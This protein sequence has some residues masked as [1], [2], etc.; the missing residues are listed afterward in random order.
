[1]KVFVVSLHRCA[2]QSVAVFLTQAG[3]SS[4][5]FP[6]IVDGVDY[7]SQVTGRETDLHSITGLLRPVFDSFE[8]LSDLPL[9]VLYRQIDAAYPNSR[10]IAIR[11]DPHDWLRSVRRHCGSR[12]L[13]PYERVQY[14]RYL[15]ER[16]T[17]LDEVADD[18]LLEMYDQHYR[19]VREYFG[20]RDDLLLLDLEDVRIGSRL[21]TFLGTRVIEFPR[22]DYKNPMT[23]RAAWLYAKELGQR[24]DMFAAR[25]TLR[26]AVRTYPEMRRQAKVWALWAATYTNYRWFAIART[27]SQRLPFRRR[28]TGA[29]SGHG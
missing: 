3:F 20:E 14:W 24:G 29:A 28:A 16:P 25:A 19:A 12:P 4:C 8:A 2:T 18:R 10:F 6:S 1:M 26:T 7:E 9:P 15:P 5:H 17:S 21:S 11:R 22:V 13:S 23:A 27:C